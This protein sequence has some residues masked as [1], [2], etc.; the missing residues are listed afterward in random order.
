[1]VLVA[2]KVV[3]KAVSTTSPD[4]TLIG[5]VNVNKDIIQSN[6]S[7]TDE[8]TTVELGKDVVDGANMDVKC[9]G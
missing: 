6:Q 5:Q 9:P 4:V 3:E 2:K 8:D 1:M 7:R